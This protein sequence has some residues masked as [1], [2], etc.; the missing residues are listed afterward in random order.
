MFTRP[1][2]SVTNQVTLGV[3]VDERR[4]SAAG[5]AGGTGSLQSTNSNVKL[6]VADGASALTYTLPGSLGTSG[7]FLS[8]ASSADG[9]LEWTTASGATSVFIMGSSVG[10]Q[11]TDMVSSYSLTL[12]PPANQYYMVFNP[13]MQNGMSLSAWEEIQCDVAGVFMIDCTVTFR[14]TTSYFTT[15]TG[16][17]TIPPASSSNSSTEVRLMFSGESAPTT[18]IIQSKTNHVFDGTVGNVYR[19]LSINGGAV[20]QQGAHYR[21]SVSS[22]LDNAIEIT[23]AHFRLVRIA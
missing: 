12:R 8:V 14:Y 1:R 2:K 4:P 16:S 17:P 15:L 10:K 18:P 5:A 21:L 11:R 9:A 20:L 6:K 3:D 23:S 22:D 13:I 7:Q 19:S